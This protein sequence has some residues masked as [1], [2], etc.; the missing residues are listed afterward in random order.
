MVGNRLLV[1]SAF[2]LALPIVV[3][4][5]GIGVAGAIALV[6]LAL[7]WRWAISLAVFVAPA[8][9]PALELETISASHFAE[10]V[11]WCLDR[12]RLEYHER[13]AAGTLGAFFLGRTVPRL[14]MR[15]G[16][17][18]SEIGNSAEILRY[19]WGAYGVPCGDAAAFLRPTAERLEFERRI[20]RAGVAL[21]VWVYHHILDDRQLS[22]HA[23]GRDNP[24]I[25]RWQRFAITLLFPLQRMLIR[26]SFRITS[27][28][29]SRS[30]ENIDLLLADAEQ[31]LADGRTSLCGGHELNYTDIAF[32]AINGLWL[33]PDGFGAGRADAVR[34]EPDD[35]PP[36]MR[37]DIDR[38][39]QAYP[40]ATAFIE[41]LYREQ[42]AVP[43]GDDGSGQAEPPGDE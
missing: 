41:R 23:W 34:I 42:R 40:R 21:Q 28:H 19:L 18:R 7:L 43:A 29:Y 25:P 8:P 9:A 11:R 16:A 24:A 33:Q 6:A 27:G 35:A 12:L 1:H 38:W 26:K 39:A 2:V 36:A 5:A 22:L 30:V 4:A 31:R 15:T 3:A 13:Q 32:A 20:D 17:V 10:K 14:R 37:A